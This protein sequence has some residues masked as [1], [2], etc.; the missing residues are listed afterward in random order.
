MQKETRALRQQWQ[1]LD[2][3]VSRRL[4]EE[5]RLDLEVS[6]IKPDEKKHEHHQKWN[7]ERFL[8]FRH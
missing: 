1:R 8:N 2:L 7:K 5:R 4:K 6:R 3:E